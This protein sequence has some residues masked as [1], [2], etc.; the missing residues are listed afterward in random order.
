MSLP[1]WPR[2]GRTAEGQAKPI[3]WVPEGYRPPPPCPPPSFAA[4]LTYPTSTSPPRFVRASRSTEPEGILRNDSL[5][6]Y[7]FEAEFIDDDD[8]FIGP[9]TRNPNAKKR[10]NARSKRSID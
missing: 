1:I 5:E 6:G 2:P 9:P 10:G 8:A 4:S 3:G 7:V